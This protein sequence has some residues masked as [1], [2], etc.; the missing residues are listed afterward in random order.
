MATMIKLRLPVA[1]ASWDH[2]RRLPGLAGV[3]LDERYG[4]VPI[5]PKESLFV[6]RADALDDLPKRRELSPEIEGAYGDVR[7]STT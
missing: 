7:I 3:R 2:V 6:V 4:L 1:R 5:N